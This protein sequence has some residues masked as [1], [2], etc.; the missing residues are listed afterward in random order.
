[1]KNNLELALC[2]LE[3][4]EKI[5]VSTIKLNMLENVSKDAGVK[6]SLCITTLS[7]VMCCIE[8]F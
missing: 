6:A 2:N 8:T 5:Y 3:K 4:A 7:H 1:M